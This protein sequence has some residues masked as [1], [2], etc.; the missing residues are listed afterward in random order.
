MKNIIILMLITT[1]IIVF[2]LPW[3]GAEEEPQKMQPIEIYAIEKNIFG[4]F[5]GVLPCA[6][7]AGINTTLVLQENG[8][9]QLTQEY[10]GKGTFIENGNWKIQN[11]NK[12][13]LEQA[14]LTFEIIPDGL[15]MLNKE[16]PSDT[17]FNTILKRISPRKR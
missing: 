2:I 1:F 16:N 3:W 8:T 12:I 6:D 7:C 10:S 9:Y 5:Q 13:Y 4:T 14:E 11:N 15:K 17:L